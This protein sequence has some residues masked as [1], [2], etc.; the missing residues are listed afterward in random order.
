MTP[1]ELDARAH[2]LRSVAR[3][4][5]AIDTTGLTRDERRELDDLHARYLGAAVGTEA[6]YVVA[7]EAQ[8]AAEVA[9]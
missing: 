5:R 2:A 8:R 1:A 6:V 9:A 3:A 7:V 4:L